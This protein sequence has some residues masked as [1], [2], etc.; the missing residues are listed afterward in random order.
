MVNSIV[1]A[2]KVFNLVQIRDEVC[3]VV[4][5]ATIRN[6][7][8]KVQEQNLKGF[9]VVFNFSWCAKLNSHFVAAGRV[10]FSVFN[11]FIGAYCHKSLTGM[12][13]KKTHIILEY[14]VKVSMA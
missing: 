10:K 8:R 6:A 7:I 12:A 13:C 14:Y 4:K 2:T 11:I 9:E 5:L 3:K 1:L